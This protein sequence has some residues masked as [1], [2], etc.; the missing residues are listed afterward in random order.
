MVFAERTSFK[1]ESWLWGSLAG[2]CCLDSWLLKEKG[3][4]R[5]RILCR[6]LLWQALLQVRWY[7]HFSKSGAMGKLNTITQRKHGMEYPSKGGMARIVLSKVLARRCYIS[8]RRSVR[9]SSNP[10]FIHTGRFQFSKSLTTKGFPV[11]FFL[12]L[13]LCGYRSE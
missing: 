4:R 6:R 9:R 2:F 1:I 12:R 11:F 13:L 7:I 8:I 10:K 5:S 3:W